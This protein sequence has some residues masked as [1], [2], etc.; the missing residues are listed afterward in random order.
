MDKKERTGNITEEQRCLLIEFMKVHPELVSGKFSKTFTYDHAAKLWQEV[1]D[2]LNACNDAEKYWKSWRKCWQDY[3]SRSKTKQA[4]INM[5]QR[6]TG[7]GAQC[8]AVL[9]LDEQEV[10][11]LIPASLT[12]GHA[13]ISES[14]MDMT[15]G[16][17]ND[18]AVEAE[19][20]EFLDDDYNII[21]AS[22]ATSAIQATEASEATIKTSNINNNENTENYDPSTLTKSK[23]TSSRQKVNEVRDSTRILADVA[24]KTYTMKK[25]FCD[26]LI[27]CKKR[28]A[29]AQERMARAAKKSVKNNCNTM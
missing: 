19:N 4:G 5:E 13:D 10:V 21:Q 22:I 11:D 24:E 16:E 18:L 27:L 9:T 23:R 15:L 14:C 17:E 26:D 3:R 25:K 6:K 28:T 1:T 29:K 8:S 2:I 20:I 12:K 7:G